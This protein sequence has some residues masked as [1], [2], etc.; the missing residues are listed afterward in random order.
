MVHPPLELGLLDRIERSTPGKVDEGIWH[1]LE[2]K[3][4]LDEHESDRVLQDILAVREHWIARSDIAP[5]FTLGAAAYADA[6]KGFEPYSRLAQKLNP[7][8]LERFGWV[9]DRV[10]RSISDAVGLQTAWLEGSAIP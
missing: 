9:F 5:F 10:G 2:R 8:L 1:M 4:L 7:I 3:P 6:A